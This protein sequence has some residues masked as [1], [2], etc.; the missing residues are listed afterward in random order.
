MWNFYSTFIGIPYSIRN[1]GCRS[2][3]RYFRERPNGSVSRPLSK[4]STSTFARTRSAKTSAY[5]PNWEDRRGHKK[6]GSNERSTYVVAGSRGDVAGL[7]CSVCATSTIIKSNKAV[8]EE[9]DRHLKAL[10]GPRGH[11]CPDD[12]CEN[13]NKLFDS[14]PKSYF[15]HGTNASGAPRKTQW[16]RHFDDST[17]KLL[18]GPFPDERILKRDRR[19]A[20]VTPMEW[21]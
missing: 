11:H 6:R 9:F 13:H 2:C 19:A 3:R 15:R 16:N 8:W 20:G 18:A 10:S 12:R 14:H 5:P 1:T 17:L 4:G 21:A 7:R